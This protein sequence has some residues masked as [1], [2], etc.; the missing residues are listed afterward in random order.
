[1]KSYNRRT[2]MGH[3]AQV[4]GTAGALGSC[5][6]S[7]L[8]RWRP[9]STAPLELGNENL[10]VFIDP[11]GGQI[12]RV[13]NHRTGEAHEVQSVEFAI[14][15]DRGICSSEQM[16]VA[17]IMRTGEHV[18]V[19]L[20]GGGYH[21]S[22]HYQLGEEWVEKWAVFSADAPLV[23][24]R[25]M[26]GDRRYSPSF[27]ECHFHSDNT[28]YN[29]PICWFLRAR[30]GGIYT[31]IEFP[32]TSGDLHDDRIRLSYGGWRSTY[33]FSS[34]K[35]VDMVEDRPAKVDLED[36]NVHLRA[37]ESFTT[38]KEFLGIFVR[39]GHSRTKALTGIPRILTTCEERLDWGEVWA[40]QSFMR[41]VLPTLPRNHVG[42]ELYMNGWWAGLPGGAI[43]NKDLD[44]YRK[45]IDESAT[46]GVGAFSFPPTWLGMAKF[47]DRSAPF[48]ETVGK[49]GEFNL[50]PAAEEAV[51]YVRSRGLVLAPYSEGSSFYRKDKPEWK[52]VTAEGVKRG[53][54]CW[55]NV[56]AID[57]FHD[58]HRRVFEKYP[59][60][61]Y[62]NWD[63]GFLPGDPEDTAAEVGEKPL[64]WECHSREHGHPPGN[65]S[66]RLYKNVTSFISRLRTECRDVA[67]IVAWAIKCGGP[68]ALRYVDS[69]ENF[70]E[71]QGPD[72]LRFQLWYN[73]NSSFLPSEKNMA[74]IWFSFE[75][76]AMDLADKSR[77]YW[78]IWYTDKTRDYEYGF[79]SALSAGVDLGFLVQWPRFASEEEKARYKGFVGKWKLWATE[80][81]SCLKHKRDLFGQPLR[82]G[83]ID[84]SA[85][86]AGGRGFIF[87]FNPTGE[88]HLGRIPVDDRILLAP[89][90]EYQVKCIY[91]DE[92][93][94][95]GGYAYGEDFVVD[96][97]AGACKIL[98]I[99][100]YD[101]R[102]LPR[103]LPRGADVQDA[104]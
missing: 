64:S 11:L 49:Q 74:Q 70:Y 76:S 18:E 44:A 57:W 81:L 68:W 66:Y 47:V 39:S 99:E 84:G 16:S 38:E 77:D 35:L 43:E 62:W 30:K 37:K 33:D 79:M 20:K 63:G 15:S 88:R 103:E 41:H 58:L 2:F 86:I 14:V 46:L 97:A 24:R 3:I 12:T 82:Q 29:V 26:M 85:H 71:N 94:S 83:G 72:D 75:P 7:V 104:F 23:L 61:R 32:F 9:S 45:A 87:L 53:E 21:A 96:L 65:V 89:G 28:A 78:K 51:Q 67:T 48:I 13:V 1:M 22:L 95:L 69:H 6:R 102:P 8:A 98:K 36:M 80:N 50:S 92:D 19:S 55:A 100:S 4:A 59:A 5:S 34:R 93:T 27:Q 10:T 40:M 73:Q 91:P 90:A 52:T 25:L 17:R 101:G 56:E 60:I 42:F 54:V 31:G